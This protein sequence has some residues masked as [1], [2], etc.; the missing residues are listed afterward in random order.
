[1]L[2][3]YTTP[4]SANGR[5]VLAVS[6]HLGLDPTVELIDVYKGEGRRPAYLALNP[7]G[8]IPTLVDDDFTLWESNA[9]L[10]YLSEA[11][12]DF[13]LSSRAPQR[14]RGCTETRLRARGAGA[15]R[16]D[17]R[18]GLPRVIHQRDVRPANL[19]PERWTR[20]IPRRWRH[21]VDHRQQD[22]RHHVGRVCDAVKHLVTVVRI[23]VRP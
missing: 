6:H 12:G 9:I 4:L 10:Q 15:P 21:A 16:A 17:S 14:G 2:T 8:K 22:E 11:Y 7:W 13:K 5:K 20:R 1:M 19:P 18:R 23:L 3:L